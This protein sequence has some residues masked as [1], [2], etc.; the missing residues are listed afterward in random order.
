MSLKTRFLLSYGKVSL[1]LG[2]FQAFS[3]VHAREIL[4]SPTSV[5]DGEGIE[6]LQA[7]RSIN[8]NKSDLKVRIG[9]KIAHFRKQPIKSAL[10]TNNVQKSKVQER[11][12]QEK[13][14]IHG[15]SESYVLSA[16]LNKPEDFY[17]GPW[18]IV[19][20]PIQW[21]KA[22]NAYTTKLVFFRKYGQFG[23]LEESIAELDVNGELKRDDKGIA[24][25]GISSTRVRNKLLE[26]IFDISAGFT[27]PKT[28]KSSAPLV[29]L[30]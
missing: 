19:H 30:K 27:Q 2:L 15:S 21:N 13:E 29:K 16:S 9:I 11:K 23:Q 25:I 10:G 3:Q 6:Q 12:V 17:F 7:K 20:Q 14:Y 28:E 24:L 26:P 18:H 5:F 1:C 22:S 4:P 8:P